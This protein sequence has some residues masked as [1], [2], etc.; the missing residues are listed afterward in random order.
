MTTKTMTTKTAHRFSSAFLG[1]LAVASL[2]L[3]TGTTA[4]AQ[5]AA[6]PSDAQLQQ[7]VAAAPA[8]TSTVVPLTGAPVQ[9]APTI[10]TV[11][12]PG[13]AGAKVEDT[14][15]K[16]AMQNGQLVGDPCPSTSKALASSPDDLAKVQEEIDRFT[17]C[18]QRAQL[19][20]RLNEG[21]LKNESVYDASLGL[22]PYSSTEIT[23]RP[24]GAPGAPGLPG[25]QRGMP[26]LPVEALAGADVTPQNTSD[27]GAPVPAAPKKD[28]KP[29]TTSNTDREAASAEMDAKEEAPVWTIREI[30]GSGASIK[31]TLLSPDGDEVRVRE[32]EK[33]PNN[34]GVVTR[35]TP[36]GVMIRDGKAAKALD[37]ARS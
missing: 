30:Y 2:M 20:E 22:S 6:P 29:D 18:V 10:D 14:E 17:L 26:P 13:Q 11:P 19:L 8:G 12:M 34:N 36:T 7:P 25:A 27:T 37:W 1:G 28:T 35:I 23:T 9:A 24:S 5:D 16:P 4:Q 33:L 3:L 31:A 15:K 21:T 32:G